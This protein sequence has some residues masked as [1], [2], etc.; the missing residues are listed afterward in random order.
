MGHDDTYLCRCPTKSGTE[1]EDVPIKLGQIGRGNR[2][3]L[4]P[5]A[6]VG[7]HEIQHLFRQSLCERKLI[8]LGR[9]GRSATGYLLCEHT[10]V[11]IELRARANAHPEIWQD[12][13]QRGEGTVV[14]TI[15]PCFEKR[16]EASEKG[17]M[18]ETP[19]YHVDEPYH[20]STQFRRS[21]VY[22]AK[23][24]VAAAGRRGNS[25][26]T[27]R[28]ENLKDTHRVRD[29]GNAAGH[30]GTERCSLEMGWW[31]EE[32]ENQNQMCIKGHA[33][34]QQRKRRSQ[35]EA[36]AVALPRSCLL[37]LVHQVDLCCCEIAKRLGC[38]GLG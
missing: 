16:A 32:E 3:E 10:A 1:G 11:A 29:D 31:W 9:S 33:D 27:K 8:D 14:G 6:L 4:V 15:P 17:R 30:D 22:G 12:D 19:P 13:E 23:R 21:S 34:T 37:G 7:V 20:M 18:P 25:E 2:R 26:R 36:I 5:Q 38:D 24:V 35:E 28:G